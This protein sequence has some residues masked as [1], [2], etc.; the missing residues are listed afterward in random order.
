MARTFGCARVVYNDALAAR[1]QVRKDGL[2]YPKSTDLQKQL[3]TAA[4]RPLSGHGLPRSVPI[5]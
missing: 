5:P 2:P 3:V 1:K 4:R